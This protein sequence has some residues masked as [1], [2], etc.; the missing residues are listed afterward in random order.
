MV[1]DAAREIAAEAPG[2]RLQAIDEHLAQDPRRVK[3]AGLFAWD[4]QRIAGNL[5][6]LPAGLEPDGMP[7]G[8]DIVR[9]DNRGREEQSVRVVAR[10]LPG[11]DV[12]VVGRNIDELDELR[13]T[14]GRA[15]ALGLVP[16]LCL[17]VLAGAILSDRARRRIEG[18]A[19]DGR[20][21]SSPAICRSACR[22]AAATIPSTSSPASSTACWTASRA[23]CARSPAPATT[24]RTI[25][26]RR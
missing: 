1:V 20:S 19:G 24:S 11:G 3:L 26:A 21:G 10:R 18:V 22:P 23:C 16:A 8:A 25:C 4:R 6:A 5:E 14:I 12:L 13:S 7:R 17:A 2:R 15:L 9:I